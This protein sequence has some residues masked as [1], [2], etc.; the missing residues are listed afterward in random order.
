VGVPVDAE[1]G[2][3]TDRQ[4]KG[5][6]GGVSMGVRVGSGAERVILCLG[7]SVKVN[8][9]LRARSGGRLVRL[10]RL[11]SR[12]L[13]TY[14]QGCGPAVGRSTWSGCPRLAGC[15]PAVGRSGRSGCLGAIGMR[16]GGRSVRLVRLPG[17]PR[18]CGSAFGRSG[19]SACLGNH[20][21]A[22]RRSVGP[23]GPAAWEP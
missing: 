19:R 1:Y 22:V 5:G 9:K 17:E 4:T 20:K 2:R 8:S 11:P 7:F 12:E 18:G 13:R 6:T 10:V 3:P 21:D 14:T 23:A 16:S 15:G